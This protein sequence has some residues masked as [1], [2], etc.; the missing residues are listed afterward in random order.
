MRIPPAQ[1]FQLSR[2]WTQEAIVRKPR[3]RVNTRNGWERL[4]ACVVIR[5]RSS[6]ALKRRPWKRSSPWGFDQ[7][8][9]LKRNFRTMLARRNKQIEK[10]KKSGAKLVV[11]Y[12]H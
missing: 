8:V 4:C 12:F 6:W 7:R 11:I 3:A 1:L 5:R 10:L 9:R 2:W